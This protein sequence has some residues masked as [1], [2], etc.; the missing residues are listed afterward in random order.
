MR[1]L[2]VRRPVESFFV[3]AFALSWIAVL[4][5]QM[6]EPIASP[7][8]NGWIPALIFSIAAIAVILVTRGRLS[9][10]QEQPP[11]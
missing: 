1:S 8:N 9:Y 2:V 11:A 4:P 6:A 7:V 5:P 10:R 3:L